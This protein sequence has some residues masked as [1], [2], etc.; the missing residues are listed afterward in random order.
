MR[1]FYNRLFFERNTGDYDE[2]VYVEEETAVELIRS[3]RQYIAAI[4]KLIN[5]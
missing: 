1:I 5:E 4:E 2:F 3:A